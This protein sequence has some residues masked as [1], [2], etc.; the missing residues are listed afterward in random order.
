[1]VNTDTHLVGTGWPADKTLHISE[2]SQRSWIVPQ[3][4][5]ATS[6]MISVTTN[7]SGDFKTTLTAAVCP[8]A[9]GSDSFGFSETCYVGVPHPVGVDT[10]K[11]VGAAKIT[12][13]GP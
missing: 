13:T 4:P 12:V 2:C 8:G 11:L 1:M 3:N 9:S 6:N 5:C 7:A 10:I